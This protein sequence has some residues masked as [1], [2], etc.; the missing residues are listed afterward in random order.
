ME[1]FVDD[2]VFRRGFNFWLYYRFFFLSEVFVD[3]W[4]F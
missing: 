1:G 4:V 3:E 2:R